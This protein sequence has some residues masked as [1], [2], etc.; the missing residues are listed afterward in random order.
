MSKVSTAISFIAALPQFAVADLLRTTE[1]YR[2]V[3]GFQ[4]ER[5]LHVYQSHSDRKANQS[6]QLVNVEAIHYLRPM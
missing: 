3:L 4:I 5:S 6:G 1:Y 2:D